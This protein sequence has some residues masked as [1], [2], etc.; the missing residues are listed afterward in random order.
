MLNLFLGHNGNLC[1]ASFKWQPGWGEIDLSHLVLSLFFVFLFLSRKSAS[2][3]ICTEK[4]KNWVSGRECSDPLW[5][6]T[7]SQCVSYISSVSYAFPINPGLAAVIVL[8][9][10]KIV[11]DSESEAEDKKDVDLQLSH[12][13]YS[14]SHPEWQPRWS[15]M[16]MTVDDSD[17]ADDSVDDKKAVDFHTGLTEAPPPK[18]WQ[19]RWQ[20]HNYQ[21]HPSSRHPLHI[22]QMLISAPRIGFIPPKGPCIGALIPLPCWQLHWWQFH[23]SPPE[24]E[25]RWQLHN[26]Q[27]HSSLDV[28]PWI[29]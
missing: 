12:R 1:S 26:Y 11:D 28:L 15:L 22:I 24:W 14:S 18:E 7:V 20:F 25:V 3:S 10:W 21:T 29:S 17:A 2:L 19:V 16:R 13:L 27:T 4:P 6:L 9:T 8:M 23:S 5:P